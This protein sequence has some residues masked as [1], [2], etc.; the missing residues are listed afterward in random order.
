MP[1]GVAGRLLGLHGIVIAVCAATAGVVAYI[2]APTV[3]HSH[4]E[5]AHFYTESDQAQHVDHAFAISMILAIAV[6]VGISVVLAGAISWVISR[7]VQRSVSHVAHSAARIGAGDYRTRV[8]PSGLASEFDELTATVNELAERLEHVEDTR[9]RM[10]SDLAHE[11]RTPLATISAT[12]EAIE[13]H[14]WDADERTLGVVKGATLRL[15][16]L[17]DDIAEVSEVTEGV[18]SMRF[19]PVGSDTLVTAAVR[20]ARA[21]FADSGVTLVTG[22][23][24]SA[25]VMVDPVRIAQVL[26]NL[27]NNAQ[28]HTPRGG[29]VSV[30]AGLVDNDRVAV[31]VADNGDG[32]ATDHLPHVF[33]RFYR[34]DSSRSREAG[35]TGIGLTIARAIVEAH[36]GTLVA[37]SEGLG[38]GAEFRVL[39]PTID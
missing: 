24:T 3:F 7:R 11:M 2:I 12:L 34:T 5:H 1:Q 8:V 31:T 29:R 16:R 38:R 28:R 20:E 15:R 37:T 36:G 18:P 6:G 9:R 35:G 21:R 30:S 13:D 19:A 22:T 27:L 4:L 14:I 26:H 23:M 17:A 10:L 39:L 32:I 25:R 33:D